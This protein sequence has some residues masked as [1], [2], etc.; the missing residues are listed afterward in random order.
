VFL[1]KIMAKVLA[2][3][4]LIGLLLGLMLWLWSLLIAHDAGARRA[5]DQCASA[6]AT[7]A[8]D[9]Q[10]VAEATLRA[11]LDRSARTGTRREQSRQSIDARFNRLQ[12][13]AHA[14]P[15]PAAAAADA[16]LCVLSDERLRLW[17]AANAGDTDPG[18]AP[19]EPVDPAATPADA[20]VGQADRLAVEPHRG[21]PAVLP[22][23]QP[24]VQPADVAA[25]AP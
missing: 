22:A 3:P 7:E 25:A 9:A 1:T 11:D 23:R 5:A 18:A 19:A 12:E 21:G 14:A 6:R 15:T 17:R 10:R 13:A 8:L 2:Q 20:S 4:K 16:A 24:D